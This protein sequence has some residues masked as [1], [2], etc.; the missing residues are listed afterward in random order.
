MKKPWNSTELD[1]FTVRTLTPETMSKLI[2][3]IQEGDAGCE[4]LQWT[5]CPELTAAIFTEDEPYL[6]ML[7]FPG[8]EMYNSPEQDKYINALLG[9]IVTG[10]PVD[11]RNYYDNE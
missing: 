4:V 8:G 2:E 5:Y 3:Q 11:W 1:H 9:E 6:C 7:F 10:I